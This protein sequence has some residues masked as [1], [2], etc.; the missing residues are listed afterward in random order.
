MILLS[1]NIPKELMI[2]GC[3]E[4]KGSW[5]MMRGGDDEDERMRM[6]GVDDGKMM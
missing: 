6:R 4:I 5:M 1:L 2:D 3:I